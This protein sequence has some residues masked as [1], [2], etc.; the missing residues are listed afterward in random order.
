M[1]ANKTKLRIR[2]EAL[3][4]GGSARVTGITSS[5]TPEYKRAFATIRNITVS[6]GRKFRVKLGAR[7][8]TITRIK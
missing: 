2:L 6:S 5:M 8:L 1:P 4:K 3:K 7:A